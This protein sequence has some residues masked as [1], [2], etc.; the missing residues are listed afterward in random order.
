MPA[1]PASVRICL[2]VFIARGQV[3]RDGQSAF[4]S[5]V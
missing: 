3:G 5:L 2:S 4:E 1:D